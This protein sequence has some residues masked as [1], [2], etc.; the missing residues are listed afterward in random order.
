FAANPQSPD[1]MGLDYYP[2]S[3]WQLDQLG[4]RVRQRRAD[5]PVGLYGVA[6]A[7]YNRYGLPLMLTETS[8]EG[9]A[10]NREIWLDQTIDDI[11]RLRGEGVPMLGMIWWPMLD[12]IDW[13]GALTHRIGKVHKVGLWTLR[14]EKDGTLRR[15]ATP[16][17]KQF[18]EAVVSGEE[19][20]GKL[21]TIA[22][23]VESEDEQLPP[24]EYT[25]SREQIDM[26]SLEVKP[27]AAQSNGNGHSRGLG[28]SPE[29]KDR[30]AQTLG[31]DAQ[32]TKQS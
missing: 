24:L 18:A 14:R 30:S 4:G 3:D 22:L 10:I 13:D 12:Q 25:G 16:L 29:R 2:H 19:R 31:Q 7:Y 1:V 26:V 9:Q 5:N 11:C 8:V 17:V 27:A 6:N 15:E 32:A 20:V 21:E 23:P 28:V